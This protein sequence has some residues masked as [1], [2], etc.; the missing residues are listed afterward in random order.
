MGKTP[1]QNRTDGEWP[2]NCTRCGTEIYHHSATCRECERT[3]RA[4]P[5]HDVG[6][7]LRVL[8]SWLRWMRRQSYPRF[9]ATVSAVAGIELLLTTL[10]LAVMSS[11][12]LTMPT[13]L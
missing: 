5:Q 9:V 1:P 4:T 3:E 12:A 10:W 11:G 13:P 8:R 6:G 2:W 7:P